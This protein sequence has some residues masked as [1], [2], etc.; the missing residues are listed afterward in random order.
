[1]IDERT[2]YSDATY[3]PGDHPKHGVSPVDMTVTLTLKGGTQIILAT[4]SMLSVSEMRDTFPVTVLAS[5][6]PVGFTRGHRITAGSLVFSVF[7]RAAFAHALP[8]GDSPAHS[9]SVQEALQ[10]TGKL[11]LLDTPADELPPL[12]VHMIY[13]TDGVTC[14]EG[15]RGVRI[16]NQGLTR[17]IETISLQEVYSFLALER[18]PLQPLALF[19]ASQSNKY[20]E[21]IDTLKPSA[22]PAPFFPQ[23]PVFLELASAQNTPPNLTGQWTTI[24]ITAGGVPVS[25]VSVFAGGVQYVSQSGVVQLPTGT[26]S[27][28]VAA[29]LG[30]AD[31]GTAYRLQASSFSLSP[32]DSFIES[33]AQPAQ[34]PV[35]RDYESA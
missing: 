24:S 30:Y 6:G 26:G 9:T 2:F 19:Q 33:G 34:A 13:Q 8:P 17:S 21:K 5:T 25:G 27:G 4:L 12:D 11:V 20:R 23:V 31:D 15:L 7:D 10:G 16:V 18:I 28:R 35:Q 1:M 29:G 14:Y 32:G 22:L 3:K